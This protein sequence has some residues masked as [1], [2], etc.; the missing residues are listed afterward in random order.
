M[1]TSASPR[2]ADRRPAPWHAPAA[3]TLALAWPVVLA[4]D[5][6]FSFRCE[7]DCG[8]G[9]GRLLFFLSIVVAPATALGVRRLVRPRPSRR[10][11]VLAMVLAAGYGL[12][13]LWL[14]V[15]WVVALPL[16]V[17]AAACWRLR[18]PPAPSSGSRGS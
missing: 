17:I 7:V 14:V 16:A 9:G 5:V 6:A 8:D 13:A 1:A 15:W 11:R 12:M 4:G 10:G 2:P 18:R 3:L